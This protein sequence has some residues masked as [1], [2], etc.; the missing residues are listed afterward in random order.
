MNKYEFSDDFYYEF[1]RALADKVRNRNY[2][3]G[4]VDMSFDTLDVMFNS[5]L[6]IEH[7]TCEDPGRLGMSMIT[8]VTPIWWSIEVSLEGEEI[9]HDF[10]FENVKEFLTC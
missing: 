1:A 5:C 9:E 2:W 10:D 7:G 8:S 4:Y 6:V 3:S